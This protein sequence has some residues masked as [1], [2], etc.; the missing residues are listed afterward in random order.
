MSPD[1]SLGE[2]NSPAAENA[3][4]SDE[5]QSIDGDS[6]DDGDQ[7]TALDAHPFPRE[8]TEE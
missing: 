8:L 4:F 7:G 3:D 6:A 5:A 1:F 2:N